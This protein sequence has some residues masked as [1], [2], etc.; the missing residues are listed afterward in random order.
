MKADVEK[1]GLL[2]WLN[3]MTPVIRTERHNPGSTSR[4]LPADDHLET[5]LDVRGDDE[6]SSMITVAIDARPES[7][8][9][10]GT[11]RVRAVI[12]WGVSGHQ[13]EAEIDVC[14]GTI[15]S[16]N[17]SSLRVSVANEGTEV[18]MIS[19]STCAYM[20]RGGGSQVHRTRYVGAIN[21]AATATVEVPAWATSFAVMRAPAA[22]PFTVRVLDGTGAA[23]YEVAVLANVD[24]F[25]IPL[26]NDA[27]D[28]LIVNGAV[29]ITD[30]RV[31]FNLAL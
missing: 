19:G 17:A 9:S 4:P 30:A 2:R 14:M 10:S 23:I 25:D 13:H 29:G 28:V 22:A 3:L 7:D 16:V 8:E 24:V 1:I 20:P 12:K 11:T 27:F 21:G 5:I 6:V 18:A 15:V 26:S 31:V